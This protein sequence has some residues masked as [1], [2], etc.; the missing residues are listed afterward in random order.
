MATGE[1][2]LMG[3]N[4]WPR[5]KA[6]YWWANFDAGEVREEFAM[7][8]EIGLTHVRFFL[9]WESFQPS[10]DRINTGAV[11][12]LR[13][14]CDI[15]ADVALKLQP[16]FFTGH[17]SGPNWAPDWL[18]SNRPIQKGERQIVSLGRPTGSERAIYNTYTEPFVV[19]A[20]KLQLRTVCGAL[21]DHP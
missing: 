11:E 15:A 5:R 1:P 17:M 10:P 8:R 9:L 4:Y 13:T 7:I 20:E 18:L 16:T 21:K 2:F 19:E 6:M 14:V 12:D 3:I